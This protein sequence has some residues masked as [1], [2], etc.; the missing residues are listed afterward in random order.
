MTKEQMKNWILLVS[1][2]PADRVEPHQRASGRVPRPGWSIPLFRTPGYTRLMKLNCD[3]CMVL[4]HDGGFPT[5][6]ISQP[7]LSEHIPQF[8]LRCLQVDW[9]K[10]LHLP[11][12]GQGQIKK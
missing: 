11:A 1:S 8:K 3:R 10:E 9:I 7:K 4:A 5:E 6:E 2:W 12:G